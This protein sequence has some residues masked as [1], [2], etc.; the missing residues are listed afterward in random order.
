MDKERSRLSKELE[1]TDSNRERLSSRLQDEHFLLKAPQEV[2]ERERKRL[3]NMVDR[4]A[5]LIE[6]LSGLGD[7]AEDTEGN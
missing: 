4:C 3:D 6:T 5:S 1:K 2:V 7:Y